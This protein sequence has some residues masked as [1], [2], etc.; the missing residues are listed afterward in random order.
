L[1]ACNIFVK[2]IYTVENT[3]IFPGL[4]DCRITIISRPPAAPKAATPYRLPRKGRE[5]ENKEGDKE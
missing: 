4:F 2:K 1:N 5:H 3:V